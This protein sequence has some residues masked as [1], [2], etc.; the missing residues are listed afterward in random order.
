MAWLY[1]GSSTKSFA[2]VDKLMHNVIQNKDFKAS[3]F[4]K[5]FSTACEAERMNKHKEK[6]SSSTPKNS[7]NAL[8][9]SPKDGWIKGSI[10]ISVPCDGFRY[11]S[12]DDAPQFIVQG[13]WYW[14]PLKVLKMAFL[15]PAALKFISMPYKEY[16][17]SSQNE[18]E[19]W[20]Y[21]ET[22]TADIFHEEYDK[23]RS[24][25]WTGPNSH[26]EPF[27]AGIIFYSNVTHLANFGDTSLWPLYMYISNQS[28]YIQAQPGEFAAHHIAYIPKVGG[29]VNIHYNLYQPNCTKAR[30]QN[31]WL[32][33]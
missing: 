10:S 19:E 31:P 29:S 9:F 32:V 28:K 16:W 21:T 18:P 23:L 12:E 1:N 27:V 30:R 25:P 8:P 15:E 13:I 4:D 5:T 22:Y 11:K 33:L 14:Q 17:K 6:G 20:I 24:N 7:D 2:D 26:L 3:D